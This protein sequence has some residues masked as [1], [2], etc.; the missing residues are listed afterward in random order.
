LRIA[1]ASG[2]GGTG[3]TA[4]VASFAALSGRAVLADCDVDAAD[5]HLIL[6]PSIRR[7]EDFS[8][9]KR[10]EILPARCTSCGKCAEICRFGINAVETNGSSKKKTYR[11]DPIAFE[12][13]V[14]GE[15]CVSE[16]RH[17]PMVHARLGVAEEDSGKLVS[18]VRQ[19]AR[20]LAEV[21]GL[22]VAGR[23]RYDRAVT[24]AQIRKLA[25]VEVKEDGSAEDIR[26]LWAHVQAA[27]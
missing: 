17:G 6:E 8:G 27:L 25:V 16:T 22:G 13:A 24:E 10:A 21:R 14:N 2:K 12:P 4:V 15:W 1:V 19:E 11:V 5:L 7:R 26:Q 3:K 20:W 9:G 23:V 18:T